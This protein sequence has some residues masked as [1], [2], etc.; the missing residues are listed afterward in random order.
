M[1]NDQTLRKVSEWLSSCQNRFANMQAAG[2]DMNGYPAI[3]QA[4][5]N[6]DKKGYFSVGEIQYLFNRS[7]PKGAL[8][9]Y[10]KHKGYHKTMGD[11]LVCPLKELIDSNLVNWRSGQNGVIQPAL[12]QAI[13]EETSWEWR[14]GNL[15]A[16]YNTSFSD[17]FDTN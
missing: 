3:K 7:H 4:M 12:I 6:F 15:R 9:K 10:N 17:L 5:E 16:K 1:A 8:P 2:L 14:M 11:M 13:S